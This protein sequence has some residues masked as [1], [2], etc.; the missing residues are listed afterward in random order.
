V[1]KSTGKQVS[2]QRA[3]QSLSGSTDQWINSK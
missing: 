2:E 3:R 1:S